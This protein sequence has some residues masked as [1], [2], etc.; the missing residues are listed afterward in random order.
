MINSDE[1]IGTA[2]YLTLI[3]EVSYK[4]T[5]LQ[6]GSIAIL[7]KLHNNF[8]SSYLPDDGFLLS[9]NTLHSNHTI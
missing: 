2:E 5:S 8:F 3:D 1:L 7:R 6:A 4:P 9:R